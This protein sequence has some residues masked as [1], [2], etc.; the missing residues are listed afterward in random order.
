MIRFLSNNKFNYLKLKRYNII[1][2]QDYI[3]LQENEIDVKYSKKD[4]IVTKQYLHRHIDDINILN[5]PI[6]ESDKLAFFI[7]FN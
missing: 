4:N 2:K 3:I 1:T 5:N 7:L 6:T